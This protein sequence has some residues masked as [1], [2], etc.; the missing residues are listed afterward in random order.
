MLEVRD[1]HVRY[2]GIAA[3]SGVSLATAPGEIVA[4][5]GANGA[6]K[7]TC[8]R[9]ISGLVRPHAGEIRL[10]GETIHGRAPEEIT[11]RGVAHVPEH[12][13]IFAPLSV[14][15]NLLLGAYPLGRQGRRA[16]LGERLDAVYALLPRLAERRHQLGGT[17][18]GGEQQMLA[19]GRALMSGPRVLLMDE[20]SLGLA[21]LVVDA[22]LATLERLRASGLSV[23]LVEQFARSALEV[24]DRAYVLRAGRVVLEGP[25]ADLARD[26][27]MVESYLGSAT[28]G[29]AGERSPR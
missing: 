2:G 25:S 26:A 15:D 7:S 23:L 1:L 19:I 8:L 28:D 10:A 27:R 9:A 14:A 3:L 16:R 29:A 24:A 11:R 21:P 4:V 22:I 13:R 6:G 18:S 5:L 17:L 20:P 12:R